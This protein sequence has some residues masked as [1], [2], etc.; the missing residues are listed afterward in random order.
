M[1]PVL[2]C[3]NRAEPGAFQ[4]QEVWPALI[5]IDFSPGKHNS[6]LLFQN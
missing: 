4:L 6:K 1:N 5:S 2:F 3:L